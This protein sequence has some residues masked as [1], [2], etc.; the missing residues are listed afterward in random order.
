MTLT[1]F[2]KSSIAILFVLTLSIFCT[3]E[4]TPP[5][6]T[7]TETSNPYSVEIKLNNWTFDGVFRTTFSMP[8]GANSVYV[9]NN[10]V[11]QQIG[12]NP[13]DFNVGSY[14]NEDLMGKL[15]LYVYDD[16]GVLSFWDASNINPGTIVIEVDG[17]K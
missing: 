15:W 10:G 4:S 16:E 7:P 14:G 3:K 5:A 2:L 11:K 6:A 17:T 9:N 1:Y 13:I 8:E 12:P